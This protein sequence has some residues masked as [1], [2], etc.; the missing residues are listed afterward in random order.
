[1]TAPGVV[2][3][4]VWSALIV[5]VIAP[6]SASAQGPTSPQRAP[7][8]SCAS[9]AELA[10]PDTTIDSAAVYPA[11]DNTPETCR[12]HASVTHPPAGDEVNVDIWM[13]VANWNGRFEGTGGGG[14]SGGSP[15]NLP[16]PVQA[17]YAA[18]STDA[19]HVGNSGSFALN[20]DGTLNWPG[21]RDFAYLGIHDMT[22]V[23]KALVSAYYGTAPEYAYF[24]GCSTGGRQGLM[25]AQRYP[26][27]YNGIVAGSPVVNYTQ[28]HSMQL[29]GELVMLK[30]NDFVPS[31]KFAAFREAAVAA[32]DALDGVSDGVIGDPRQ[33][34]FDPASLVG[35]ET[36][37]GTIT[38]T[39]ADVVDQ[40]IAG[41]RYQDGR[42]MWYGLPWG[43]TF[44][45]PGVNDTA[46]VNGQLTGQPFFATLSCV[47][48]RGVRDPR[49]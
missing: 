8:R 10:L 42:F 15:A 40:I 18:G 49:P 29:W 11:D 5:G 20:P 27:D 38:Q 26:T 22:V 30:A 47:H 33:C 13:P 7:V 28:F 25:E 12:V 24:N 21:I 35:T 4:L 14:E 1:M 48:D 17:G 34:H 36:S 6:A 37:C 45:G 23:G 41:P 46:V 31:C 9:L 43:A 39:D 16:G 44:T 32:C 2:L 19:G 3:V